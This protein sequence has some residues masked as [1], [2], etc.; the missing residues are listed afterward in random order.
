VTG[1]PTTEGLSPMTCRSAATRRSKEWHGDPARAPSQ[2]LR[3][4][5]SLGPHVRQGNSTRPSAGGMRPHH[6]L[7]KV[8]SGCGEHRHPDVSRSGYATFRWGSVVAKEAV[9]AGGVIVFFDILT[10]CPVFRFRQHWP[11]ACPLVRIA[12]EWSPRLLRQIRAPEVV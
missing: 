5:G 7:H 12:R 4:R 2:R 1:S 9:A 11:P 8:H 10:Q 3:Y 6:R